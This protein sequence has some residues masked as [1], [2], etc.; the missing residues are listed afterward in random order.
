MQQ[1]PP[2][3]PHDKAALSTAVTP[4]VKVAPPQS[5]NAV[6][7]KFWDS[8]CD[9]VRR[10]REVYEQLEEA[11]AH[12]EHLMSP[13]AA[14]VGAS[15][16][17]P[18]TSG[19]VT[20]SAPSE[21]GSS[22]SVPVGRSFAPAPRIGA[23]PTYIRTS[24]HKGG[25]GRRTSLS[26]TRRGKRATMLQRSP[27]TLGTP[28]RRRVVAPEPT[29]YATGG[30]RGSD[31]PPSKMRSNDDGGASAAASPLKHASPGYPLVGFGGSS[32]LSP[33]QILLAA[34]PAR[35]TA[36]MMSKGDSSQSMNSTMSRSHKI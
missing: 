5:F 19:T 36:R 32:C 28:T 33:S 16:S 11:V 23:A 9:H 14:H 26:G 2:R 21:C 3:L 18:P 24:P 35:P 27:V 1:S 10:G 6:S 34:S 8:I 17:E 4:K 20:P 13:M 25:G 15:H 7:P 31:T 29:Y 12:Q 30:Y 22:A